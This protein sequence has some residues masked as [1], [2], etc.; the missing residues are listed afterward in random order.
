MGMLTALRE[1][2]AWAFLALGLVLAVLTG[3]A[4]Y[5]VALQATP[6]AAA[7]PPPS[8]GTVAVVVANV[9]IPARTVVTT[10]QLARR[11]F[12]TAL[13]PSGA[14]AS[15][16]QAVGQTTI[17]PIAR[18]QPVVTSQLAAAGGS[19]GASLT[20]PAGKV[21]VAF[22]TTDP[23]TLNGLV[24]VGDRIDVLASVAAGTGDRAR[25][26]QTVLQNLEV[27]QVIA[28]TKEDPQR[29]SALVFAVDHQVALVLKYLRDSQAPID[30]AI[31]SR[32]QTDQIKTTS[33]DLGY[34]TRTY[35]IPR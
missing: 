12:P 20:V 26:T 6:D 27:L 34:L 22:P 7:A 23:L 9:D 11:D 29:A 1:G 14:I 24:S 18:G 8:A 17:A 30:L 13:A 4:L 31:R 2:R 28:P 15:E 5:R 10:E 21:L 19:T 25:V 33:V 32:S 35:E 16:A 3:V